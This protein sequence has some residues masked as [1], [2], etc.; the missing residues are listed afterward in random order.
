MLKAAGRVTLMLKIS[1]A[2]SWA[3]R[4]AEGVLIKCETNT[5]LNETTV[6]LGER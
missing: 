2:Y 6:L 4:I 3:L 1:G 5:A